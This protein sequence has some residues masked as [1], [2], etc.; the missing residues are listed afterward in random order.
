MPSKILSVE[1]VKCGDVIISVAYPSGTSHAF[2]LT[3]PDA[4]A[5]STAL[6]DAT[7]P[8]PAVD[9]RA[10]LAGLRRDQ[11]QIVTALQEVARKAAKFDLIEIS[12]PI[13]I[14]GGNVIAKSLADELKSMQV[15]KGVEPC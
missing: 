13:T 12:A 7:H 8:T 11:Q 6:F 15:H 1:R 2:T 4:A 3:G 5:L 14:H 9:V 10:E